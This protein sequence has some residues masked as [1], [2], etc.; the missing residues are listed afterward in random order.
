MKHFNSKMCLILFNILLIL[1]LSTLSN[2]SPILIRVKHDDDDDEE[3]AAQLFSSMVPAGYRKE[4]APGIIFNKSKPK[5]AFAVQVQLCVLD[6]E[7]SASM[8]VVQRT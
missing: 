2:A 6:I 4:V 7:V 8:V 1:L 3:K 5:D